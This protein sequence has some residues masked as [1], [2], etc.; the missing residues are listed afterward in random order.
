[1][2]SDP[3]REQ[4]ALVRLRQALQQLLQPDLLHKRLG[5]RPPHN[6]GFTRLVLKQI[7]PRELVLQRIELGAQLVADRRAALRAA[8]TDTLT[9]DAGEL[10]CGVRGDG[11]LDVLH[12][13]LVEG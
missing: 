7:A 4:R 3:S 5:D 11:C 12:V 2:G 9:P 10:G 13:R 8:E 1:M 6:S